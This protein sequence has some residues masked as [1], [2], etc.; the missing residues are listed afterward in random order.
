MDAKNLV[1]VEDVRAELIIPGRAKPIVRS[2]F[3]EHLLKH[4]IQT[5]EMPY[6]GTRRAY[7]TKAEAQKIIEHFKLL[8]WRKKTVEP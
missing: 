6:Q 2:A 4:S 1:W 3:R 7:I 5:V 8:H